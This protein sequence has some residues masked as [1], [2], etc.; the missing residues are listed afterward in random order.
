M[1]G[2]S[3]PPSLNILHQASLLSAPL[4]LST[5]TLSPCH[6][7]RL[8]A[9][10][11]VFVAARRELSVTSGLW[12]QAGTAR[13]GT[14]Q[15]SALRPQLALAECRALQGAGQYITHIQVNNH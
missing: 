3:A 14:E 7:Q 15:L 4:S 9:E 1:N 13:D 8:R 12:R 10:I 11:I 2:H 5:L 6:H